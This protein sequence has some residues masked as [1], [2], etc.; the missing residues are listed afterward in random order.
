MSDGWNESAD[1]WIASMGDDG[2]WGRRHVLDPVMRERVKLGSYETA[3]DIG[4]GEGRFCR[5]MSG[6]GIRATGIDPTE[7]L[8]A[9]AR[10]RDPMGDYRL[11]RAENLEFDD[12]SFDLVVSY[13][14]LMD[15][16]DIRACHP[17]NGTCPEAGRRAAHC[18]DDQFQHRRRVR[19][20]GQGRRRPLSALPRRQLSRRVR[21]LGG[22][23]RHPHPQLAPPAR[24]LHVVVTGAGR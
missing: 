17:G 14:T 22:M 7:S 9:R 20:L 24:H 16:P 10:E 15:V 3:I 6:L 18:A 13:L 1:A 11:G 19:R 12:A 8:L 4:C 2:D 5:T 21:S 23:A